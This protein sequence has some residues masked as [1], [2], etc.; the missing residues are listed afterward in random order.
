M[1]KKQS[2][3]VNIIVV[4]N[5]HCNAAFLFFKQQY[6]YN[7]IQEQDLKNNGLKEY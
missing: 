3:T 2:K 1:H 7:T 4:L 6:A 5:N